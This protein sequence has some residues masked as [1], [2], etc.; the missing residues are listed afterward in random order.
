MYLAD[1]AEEKGYNISDLYVNL[2]TYNNT[3]EIENAV[4]YT[5]YYT[6]YGNGGF[7]VEL[8]DGK[9]STYYYDSE[10]DILT[11]YDIAP[12]GN[13]ALFEYT[14][15]YNPINNLVLSQGSFD[16]SSVAGTWTLT[17]IGGVSYGGEYDEY[18]IV[19]ENDGRVTVCG[20]SG[21]N[22]VSTDTGF[23]IYID[24]INYPIWELNYDRNTDTLTDSTNGENEIY[25]FERK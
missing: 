20:D 15:G 16:I 3:I 21:Y 8:P 9:E 5:I 22:A 17:K 7:T 14:E 6:V 10:K 2:I 25:L 1:Y 19:V 12:D 13:T 4:G 18:T 24:G 23:R 11:C